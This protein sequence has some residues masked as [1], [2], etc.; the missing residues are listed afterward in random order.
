MCGVIG[1]F[2]Y[3]YSNIIIL[4]LL[5]SLEKL[6]NRGRD[7]Y[8]IL[9]SNNHQNIIIKEKDIID[10][11]K[12]KELDLHLSFYNKVLGHSRYATSYKSH[13]DKNNVNDSHPIKGNHKSLGHFFL[14]H[15]GNINFQKSN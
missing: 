14:V 7:S 10:L 1:I 15:N 11:K 6:Q 8:G 5:K 2:N 4:E 13:S 12:I 9:L 3:Q